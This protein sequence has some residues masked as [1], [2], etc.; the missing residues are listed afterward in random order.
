MYI[1]E[2]YLPDTLLINLSPYHRYYYIVMLCSPDRYI[3]HIML[4]YAS[5]NNN[6]NTA[7]LFE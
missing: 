1:Y 5:N 4:C 6:N 3:C 7:G 2:S